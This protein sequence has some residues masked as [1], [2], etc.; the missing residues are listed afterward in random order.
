[1]AVGYNL[2]FL[3]CR[4]SNRFAVVVV[5]VVDGCN[6]SCLFFSLLYIQGYL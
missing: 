5:V 1:M 2:D 6:E 3:L 4:S